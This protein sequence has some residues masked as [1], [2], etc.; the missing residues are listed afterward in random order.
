[1]HC[2]HKL[3]TNAAIILIEPLFKRFCAI[4]N[5]IKKGIK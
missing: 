5:E 3:L 1:M 4:K 2:I